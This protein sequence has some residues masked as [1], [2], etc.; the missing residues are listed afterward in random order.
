MTILLTPEQQKQFE[1]IK[2][3]FLQKFNKYTE[4]YQKK[5]KTL[6]KKAEEQ[7]LERL[8]NSLNN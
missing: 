8:R 5:I 6:I 2:R 3:E 1:K 4:Q 7:K